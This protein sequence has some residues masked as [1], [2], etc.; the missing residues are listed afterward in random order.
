MD[1]AEN[2]SKVYIYVY[3]LEVGIS[4]LYCILLLLR[5]GSLL[6]VKKK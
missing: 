4:G 1:Y 3:E 2:I 5:R 6:Y